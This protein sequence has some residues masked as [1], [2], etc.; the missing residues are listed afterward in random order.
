MVLR[1]QCGEVIGKGAIMNE[2]EEAR[3]AELASKH[4]SYIGALLFAHGAA[5]N[6]ID[7][8][9]FHYQQ[10]FRHGYKHAIEDE[11]GFFYCI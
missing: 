8:C 5:E 9:G 7:M 4:W 1:A 2:Q 3:A 11:R 10:A 6:I